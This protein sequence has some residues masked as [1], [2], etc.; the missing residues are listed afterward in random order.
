MTILCAYAKDVSDSIHKKMWCTYTN[1]ICPRSRYCHVLSQMIMSEGFKKDGCT[2]LGKQYKSKMSVE[3]V[4]INESNPI[5]DKPIEK[6]ET[7][8][9]EPIIKDNIQTIICKVNYSKGNKTSIQYK[10]NGETYNTFVA[11]V[12]NGVVKIKY[13]NKFCKDNIL[14]ILEVN[15]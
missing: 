12:Y 15:K 11:G 6:I 2:I 14:E 3:D 4:K 13:K 10:V 5:I 7:K 9:K 1:N 8:D